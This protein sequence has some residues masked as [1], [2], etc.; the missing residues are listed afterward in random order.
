MPEIRLR[1]LTCVGIAVANL[2]DDDNL[3]LALPLEAGSGTALD[4]ALDRARERYGPNA[5]TRAVLLG[6]DQELTV[7]LLP[8]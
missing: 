8:D 3:Q 7:P 1:G 4:E 2:D 5:V 6:R